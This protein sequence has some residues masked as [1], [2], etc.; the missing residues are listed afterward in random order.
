MTR[1][2]ALL[3]FAGLFVAA[4]LVVC[5]INTAYIVRDAVI[6]SE[7]VAAFYVV[8]FFPA[9]VSGEV[10]LAKVS[11]TEIW[12]LRLALGFG[13]ITAV[14]VELLILSDQLGWFGPDENRSALLMVSL[15]NVGLA[16]SYGGLAMIG[17]HSSHGPAR[18]A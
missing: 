10:M 12:R 2:G 4:I 14:V 8:F 6:G 3:L 15:V 18:A 9:L 11:V 5:E 1:G 17:R 13:V 16:V 7:L